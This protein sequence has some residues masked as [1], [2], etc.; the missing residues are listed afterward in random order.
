MSGSVIQIEVIRLD[1]FSVIAFAVGEAEET[2]LQN[3]ILAIPQ[4]D[5]KTEEL[6]VIADAGQA[7]F[8]PVIRSRS[9]LVVAEI[10]P[11]VSIR[12]VVFAN[13]SPL[14]L[15]QVRTPLSPWL[16]VG[17][18]SF[19]PGGFGIDVHWDTS[20]CLWAVPADSSHPP[21][22]IDLPPAAMGG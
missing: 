16:T 11:G 17:S 15:G 7:I 10:C 19:E 21:S 12:A 13:R 1:V 8:T 5:G 3:R 9:G 14:P 18:G 20:L 6:P 4:S 22:G 2:L